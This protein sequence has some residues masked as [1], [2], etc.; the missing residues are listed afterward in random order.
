MRGNPTCTPPHRMFLTAMRRWLAHATQ[1]LR[2]IPPI[3]P[4]PDGLWSTTL[5]AYPFLA[6]LPPDERLMLRTLAARFLMTKQFHGA[7]GLPVTDAMALAIAAQACLPVLGW[8]LRGLGPQ[9]GT[10]SHAPAA[11]REAAFARAAGRALAWYSDFVGIV[12][13]PGE[14]VAQ[15][16]RAD[17][18]GVVHRWREPLLGEAMERGPVTL[19]WSAVQPGAAE[20][21]TGNFNVVVHE[22]AHKLDMRTGDADGCPPLPRGFAGTATQGAARRAWRGMLL[23][24]YRAF[25]ERWTIAERFG[26]EP[27]WLDAYGTTSPAEFF[28]VAC[29]GYFV[30]RARFAQDQPALL[31]L[32]DA[33]FRPA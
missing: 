12:V 24:A 17:A 20:G 2:G 8:A 11:R 28:A 22:F 3:A 14:M 16:E 25:C 10:W 13:H 33:F 6:A 32:F 31:P 19:A 1:V 27:P 4:V 30:D 15:R 26:G 23:P 18:D 5:A 29:E 21:R 7:H 9:R